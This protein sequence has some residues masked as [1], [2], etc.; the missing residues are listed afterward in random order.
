[1]LQRPSLTLRVAIHSRIL[2]IFEPA[3]QKAQHQSYA[4]GYERRKRGN[5]SWRAG[6]V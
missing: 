2:E 4:S 1:M 3:R 5:M 6:L